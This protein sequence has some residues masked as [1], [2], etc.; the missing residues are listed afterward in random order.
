M[1]AGAETVRLAL[2]NDPVCSGR[3][4]SGTVELLGSLVSLGQLSPLDAVQ[5]GKARERADLLAFLRQRRRA[6]QATAVKQPENA[7]WASAIAAQIGVEIEAIEQ[8][9][10]EG[11]GVAAAPVF[12]TNGE[13]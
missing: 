2:A 4:A 3:V 12:S 13:G 1:E 10:H 7:E 5:V 6:A 9:L 11:E 8:G